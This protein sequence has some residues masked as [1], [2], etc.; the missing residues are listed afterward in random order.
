M[1]VRRSEAGT[2][3]TPWLREI[4]CS[5]L[6][7]SA[8]MA[9]SA[10]GSGS[11]RKSCRKDSTALGARIDLFV[12]AA[13]LAQLDQDPAQVLGVQKGDPRS[14]R[15]RPRSLVDR[16]HSTRSRP[17][18]RG[19]EIRDLEAHVMKTRPLAIQELR[20]GVIRALRLQQLERDR[21]EPQEH[22]A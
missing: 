15:A 20:D 8:G 7:P 2:P 21:T 10:R 12:P 9:T 5:W 17:S 22:D 14:V 19:L 4:A 1:R 16:L 13:A 11:G 3:S 18:Q 6:P